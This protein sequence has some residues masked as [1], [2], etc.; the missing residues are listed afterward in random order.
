M[1]AGA[2]TPAS[3]PGCGFDEDS[4]AAER[5]VPVEGTQVAVRRQDAV[6]R[7]ESAGEAHAGRTDH[8]VERGSVRV[9]RWVGEQHDYEGEVVGRLGSDGSS[10]V[11]HRH[12]SPSSTRRWNGWR[13]PWQITV[14]TS[15][16]RESATILH[17][18]A[19]SARPRTSAP[20]TKSPKRSS[21]PRPRWN[22]PGHAECGR[23]NS[24]ARRL[25][26]EGVQGRHRRGEPDR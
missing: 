11:D 5:S 19:R 1:C 13:S 12:W 4:G 2:R 21:T 8:C 23:L 22:P 14:V 15:A 18:S 16:G 9:K 20:D 3:L 7:K 17:P 24:R 6:A 25:G 26:I 10:P